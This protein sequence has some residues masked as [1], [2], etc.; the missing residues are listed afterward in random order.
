MP[1]SLL[2]N[3]SQSVLGQVRLYC[4][5]GM[6]RDVVLAMRKHLL[7]HAAYAHIFSKLTDFCRY[8]YLAAMQEEPM[9]SF[10]DLLPSA[11]HPEMSAAAE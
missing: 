9:P 2:P 10:D 5:T 1:L 3:L 4:I 11:P 6:N 7:T 8:E